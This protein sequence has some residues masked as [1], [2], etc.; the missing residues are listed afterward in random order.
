MMKTIRLPFAKC[1]RLR[2]VVALPYASAEKESAYKAVIVL[3]EENG[4]LPQ[5]TGKLNDEV[6]LSIQQKMEKQKRQ[7]ALLLPRFNAETKHKALAEQL[8][9]TGLRLLTDGAQFRNMSGSAVKVSLVVQKAFI[10]VNEKAKRRLPRPQALFATR[11]RCDRPFTF[12]VPH[13]NSGVLAFAG[14]R[15]SPANLEAA[16]HIRLKKNCD[17]RRLVQ[18]I[19]EI[20]SSVSAVELGR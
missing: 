11:G 13:L 3:A 6:P 19:S 20:T 10:Q 2:K 4:H 5:I 8:T 17:S 18:L 14:L 16:E 7:A 9:T 1:A 15:T 12:L